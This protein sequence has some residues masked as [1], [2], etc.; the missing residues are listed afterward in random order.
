LND[1]PL[2][3]SIDRDDF[4]LFSESNSRFLVEVAPGDKEEFEKTMSKSAFSRIGEVNSSDML[5][6]Y[7]LKDNKVLSVS[8]KK[9]KETWQKP[10]DW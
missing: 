2:N 8:I 4:I 6:I 7:G 1:V 10:L 9:L 3:D 5:D